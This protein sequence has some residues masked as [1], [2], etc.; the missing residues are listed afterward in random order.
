M[1]SERYSETSETRWRD[2]P[3][4]WVVVICYMMAFA[5]LGSFWMGTQFNP[6][7]DTDE[8]Q[9]ALYI[10]NW[11]NRTL[12]VTVY[13]FG[14]SWDTVEVTLDHATNVTIKVTWL[15]LGETVVFIHC[16]APDIY[17]TVAYSLVPGQWR[18]VLLI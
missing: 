11:T 15:D 10:S 16:V 2:S 1:S 9:A 3:S 12:N 17:N 18:S 8:Y 13:V 6:A 14:N 4:F 7:V 5:M